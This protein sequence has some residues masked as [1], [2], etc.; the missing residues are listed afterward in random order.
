MN[1]THLVTSLLMVLIVNNGQCASILAAKPVDDKA[2]SS[3]VLNY[4]YVEDREDFVLLNLN[5]T[6][7]GPKQIE[8]CS[9]SLQS[10]REV[11]G[12]LYW[13]SAF[14]Y[15]VI[16]SSRPESENKVVFSVLVKDVK[17][18]PNVRFAVRCTYSDGTAPQTNYLNINKN[19]RAQ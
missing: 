19:L 18:F 13:S 16:H 2:D 1:F 3:I 7:T 12:K 6:E 4:H 9:L 11:N 8:E 14:D 10:Q 5:A 15:S 17:P